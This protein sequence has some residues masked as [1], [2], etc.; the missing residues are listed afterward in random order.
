MKIVWPVSLMVVLACLLL[1]C[2]KQIA[3][4]GYVREKIPIQIQA[5]KTVTVTFTLSGNGPNDVGIKC[6]PEL[7]GI[8]FDSKKAIEVQLSSS[9]KPDTTIYGVNPGGSPAGPLRLVPHAYFL[10][11]IAGQRDTSA[12]VNITFP[13][14]PQSAV[15]AEIVVGM[16]PADTGP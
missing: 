4:E 8:L 14:A 6:T 3:G 5:G 10:F 13:N 7:W 16:T 1:S 15:S 9:E 2:S 11:E 12:T